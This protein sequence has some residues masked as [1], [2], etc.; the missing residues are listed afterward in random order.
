MNGR[1]CVFLPFIIHHSSFPPRLRCWPIRGPRRNSNAFRARRAP[2][3]TH[4]AAG[5]AV[6]DHF[7]FARFQHDGHLTNRAL[8][9]ADAAGFPAREKASVFAPNSSPHVDLTDR[10]RHQRAA[11]ATV[12]AKQSIA[13]NA[14]GRVDVDVWRTRAGDAARINLDRMHRADF[15]AFPASAAGLAE[16]LLWQRAGRANRCADHQR[17]RRCRRCRRR[18]GLL[19]IFNCCLFQIQCAKL[20]DNLFQRPRRIGQR[21]E[22]LLQT[23]AEKSYGD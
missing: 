2:I 9:H 6:V 8:V 21:A 5:A 3:L 16:F 19:V 10:C 14:R 15:H 23:L 22:Q 11:G 17:I 18:F 4:P 13:Q 12:H 1:E 7:H 20:L